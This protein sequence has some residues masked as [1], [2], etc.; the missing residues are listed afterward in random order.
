MKLCSFVGVM[1]VME[2]TTLELEIPV[3]GTVLFGA[4]VRR[5]LDADRNANVRPSQSRAGCFDSESLCTWQIKVSQ[6]G[7]VGA[8]I[9]KSIY[10]YS[11]R[12]CSGLDNWAI[13]AGCRCGM[14]DGTFADA[15]QY[16]ERW[17]AEQPTK[18]VVYMR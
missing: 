10:G 13:I 6:A 1:L 16:A 11:L 4:E 2:T 8:E 3:S 9:C 12:Y 14:L 5:L 7:Y 15:L 17:Q 18:R